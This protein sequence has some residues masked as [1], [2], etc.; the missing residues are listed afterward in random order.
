MAVHQGKFW[1]EPW[2][3]YA[4]AH[5]CRR[6]RQVLLGSPERLRLQLRCHQ[7]WPVVSDM[8]D[9][10]LPLP[11]TV[12]YQL[13][14]DEDSNR[15]AYTGWIS[16]YLAEEEWQAKVHGALLAIAHISRAVNVLIRPGRGVPLGQLH[17]LVAAGIPSH[18]FNAA[19]RLETLHLWST[20]DTELPESFLFQGA[21]QLRSLELCGVLCPLFHAPNLVELEFHEHPQDVVITR[22]FPDE[23]VE[24][25]QTMPLLERLSMT[26]IRRNNYPPNLQPAKPLITLPA[27]SSFSFKGW[28]GGIDVLLSRIEAPNL[29]SFKYTLRDRHFSDFLTRFSSGWRD[30]KPTTASILIDSTDMTLDAHVGLPSSPD[31]RSI[32]II[33]MGPPDGIE[34]VVV[35]YFS[36][37]CG[38]MASA[39]SA[40]QHLSIRE[41]VP[42]VDDL[43][44]AV[45]YA[46]SGSGQDQEVNILKR[47]TP[48]ATMAA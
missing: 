12:D 16:D 48:R 43:E 42:D 24:H 20:F 40:V 44:D 38:E 37:L 26:F 5:V 34:T 11:L 45:Y 10:S 41:D 47:S 39:L 27:L 9:H 1:N 31:Y 19:P 33:A 17:S 6:W 29:R 36:E 23:L 15:P 30:L 46:G 8:L 35:W 28:Y 32:Q 21:P 25:L 2:L 13:E 22:C 4:L 18:V 7:G 3:W 14:S